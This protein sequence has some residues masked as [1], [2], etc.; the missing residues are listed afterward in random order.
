MILGNPL[1]RFRTVEFFG[2]LFP[3]MY[4]VASAAFGWVSAHAGT[5][6]SL[7]ARLTEHFTGTPQWYSA[8][9]VICFAYLLGSVIRAFPVASLDKPL[10]RF[11]QKLRR[12]KDAT[13]RMTRLYAEAF[14][15]RSML[16]YDR[17][18]LAAGGCISSTNTGPLS[19]D[20]DAH[21]VF[22]FCKEYASLRNSDAAARIQE[23]EAR[24]RMFYGMLWANAIGSFMSL[25]FALFGGSPLPLLW[26]AFSV[27]MAGHSRTASPVCPW[28]RGTN[29]LLRLSDP[30]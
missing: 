3:G 30:T 1:T 14:P 17:E 11:F 7:R 18:Q 29:S 13:V 19:T 23:V 6:E 24:T 9:V 4:I 12:K 21:I 8:A 22:D 5:W 10:G 16:E 28:A 2:V 20:C 27:P 26:C 25:G 15:Y